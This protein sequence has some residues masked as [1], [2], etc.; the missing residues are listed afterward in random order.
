V[1]A[2]Q[3]I[4][5]A[6]FESVYGYVAYRVMPD[7]AAAAD[8]TQDVFL[9]AVRT[10]PSF[11]HNG[12]ILTWLRAIARR[13]VADHFRSRRRTAGLVEA[14]VAA[15][16][17]ETVDRSRAV[18]RAM[19]RLPVRYVELLEAKYLD[20]LSV[21]AIARERRETPKAVESALTR[22]REAFRQHFNRLQGT[23]G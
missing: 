17:T 12:S 13:R 20:E 16:E 2:F 4:F 18:A 14:D 3:G 15:P 22:A 10:W 23:E 19:R 9:A 1:A 8:I 5:E 6:H 11:R 21:E 7:A